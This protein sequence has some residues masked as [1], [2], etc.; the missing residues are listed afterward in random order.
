MSAQNADPPTIRLVSHIETKSGQQNQLQKKR[1]REEHSSGRKR[2]QRNALF[3]PCQIKPNRTVLNRVISDLIIRVIFNRLIE[4]HANY[5]I[6]CFLAFDNLSGRAGRPK[7][8]ISLHFS[9]IFYSC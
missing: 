1:K 3:K 7:T 9:V 6:N 8:N 5:H 4:Q 2:Q